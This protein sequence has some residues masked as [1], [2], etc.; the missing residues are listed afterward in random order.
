MYDIITPGAENTK[1]TLFACPQE[2]YSLI[3]KDNM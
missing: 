2:P 3:E 1:T